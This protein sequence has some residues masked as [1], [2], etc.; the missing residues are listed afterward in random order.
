MVED[1]NHH[2]GCRP[3]QGCPWL[4]TTGAIRPRSAE[5]TRSPAAGS[6]KRNFSNVLQRLS[7]ISRRDS[8]ELEKEPKREFN[9]LPL[10]VADHLW[11]TWHP[12]IAAWFEAALNGGRRHDWRNSQKMNISARSMLPAAQFW[13][14]Q[15]QLSLEHFSIGTI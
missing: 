13:G 2:A 5:P 3:A 14:A 9:G 11:G 8:A 6:R 4:A 12:V 7:A 1:S 10:F 15:I